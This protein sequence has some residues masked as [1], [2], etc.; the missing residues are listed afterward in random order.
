MLHG[1]SNSAKV[2]TRRSPALDSTTIVEPVPRAIGSSVR[3]SVAQPDNASIATPRRHRRLAEIGRRFIELGLSGF[4]CAQ[5]T[6]R[7]FSWW[8]ARDLVFELV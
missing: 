8:D 4:A 6:P 2:S 3:G 5:N 1:Y 7:K